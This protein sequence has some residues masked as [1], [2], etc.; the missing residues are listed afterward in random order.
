MT[1]LDECLDYF[2]KI[3]TSD[4]TALPWD[5]WYPANHD[6]VE[7]VFALH[8]YVRLKYRGV[9]GAKQILQRLGRL[10]PD[11]KPAP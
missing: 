8:D 11:P 2:Y 4:P 1:L 9:L 7:Q 3:V 5:E 6:K 10:P